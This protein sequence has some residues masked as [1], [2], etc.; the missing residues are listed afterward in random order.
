MKLHLK[1]LAGVA[2]AGML[3]SGCYSTAEGRTKM[4]VP[5]SKDK[6]ESRYERP[7]DQVY[8]A[9]KE[10]LKRNGT[11]EG[12]NTISHVVWA[13]VDT[14]TVWVKIT[15]V[16]PKITGVLVQARTKGG[17]ADVELASEIDKQIALQMVK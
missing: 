14:R 9:A 6:I 2:L 12:E 4:G 11:L 5:F 8:A 7:Q 17:A 3:A 13:K 15:E 16:E 1:L 10:V